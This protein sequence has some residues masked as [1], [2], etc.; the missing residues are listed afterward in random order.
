[1]SSERW[2]AALWPVLSAALPPA[3]ARVVEIGCGSLGGFVPL[4]LSAGYDAVGIDPN[5]P[6]GD[7]YR[8]VEF[9][10]AERFEDVG[11]VVAAASLHHVSEPRDVLRRIEDTLGP[12]GRVVVVEWAW[13]D[14]AEPTARWCFERLTAGE[15]ATWLH[16]H[17]ERW[18]ASGRPWADYLQAWAR[19]ERLHEASK[20]VR[21][22]DERFEREYL[23]RQPYFFAE[24]PE[25][26]EREEQAAID[27]GAI[28]ATRIDYVGRRGA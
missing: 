24:L 11:A 16:R 22:L 9:E 12:E 5:A 27:A 15:N 26:S 17:R 2:L 18:L 23:A 10:N 8:R 21:L 25:T 3:P 1:M 6:E 13:E 7:E 4:L 14:F 28:R 20:L 19:E